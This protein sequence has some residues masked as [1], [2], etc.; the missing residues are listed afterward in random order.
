M[1]FHIT[2]IEYGKLRE[3]DIGKLS[4]QGRRYLTFESNVRYNEDVIFE[5]ENPDE[6]VDARIE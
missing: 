1:E 4:F 6:H 5:T 3:G 2:G